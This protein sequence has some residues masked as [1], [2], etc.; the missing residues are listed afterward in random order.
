VN[1]VGRIGNS[2]LG[3]VVRR[4]RGGKALRVD[5]LDRHHAHAV[6]NSFAGLCRVAS[7][8]V[9]AGAVITNYLVAQR[10]H[11]SGELGHHDLYAALARAET[12]MSN[13]R[14]TQDNP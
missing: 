2:G 5:C 1:H 12:L 7:H 8:H 10:R 9:G 6:H 4:A 11:P 13:H 3:R 14:N